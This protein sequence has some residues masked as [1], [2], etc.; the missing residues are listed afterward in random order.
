MKP[1]RPGRRLRAGGVVLLAALAACGGSSKKGSEASTSSKPAVS[2]T[3]SSSTTTLSTV[4]DA[5]ADKAVAESLLLVESDLP[6]GW[7]GHTPEPDDPDSAALDK[8]FSECAGASDPTHS[9]ADVDG[10]DFDNGDA[11]VGSTAS[12]TPTRAAFEQDMAA[13]RSP[14]FASCSKELFSGAL[15]R[16]LQ[17]DSPDATVDALDITPLTVPTYGEITVGLRMKIVAT[18]TGKTVTLYMDN[19]AYGRDRIEVTLVFTNVG[20]PF[21]AELEQT[22]IK[23][24]GEKLKAAV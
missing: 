14:K 18:V 22:I 21:D 5:E 2:T 13:L 19:V 24:A 9:T 6:P 15:E 11:E 4:P 7:V 12:V 17:K 10:D 3:S 8:Q 23:T 1:R 20:T 16:Q